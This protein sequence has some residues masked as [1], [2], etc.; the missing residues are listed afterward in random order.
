M[1]DFS[2]VFSTQV[3]AE[4]FADHMKRLGHRVTIKQ[5]GVVPDLPWDYRALRS[6]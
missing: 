4:S 2:V 1:I 3:L 6:C 5:T